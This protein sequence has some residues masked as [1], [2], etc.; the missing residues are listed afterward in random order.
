MSKILNLGVTRPTPDVNLELVDG[1]FFLKNSINVN[2]VKVVDID[3][4]PPTP[5]V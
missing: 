4:K 3:L 1:S 2:L 5:L